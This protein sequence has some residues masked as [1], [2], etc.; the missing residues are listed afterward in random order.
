M[1]P[2]PLVIS[3]RASRGTWASSAAIWPAPK[4]ILVG[5]WKVKFCMGYALSE[6]MAK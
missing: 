1:L 5:L 3:T 2:P 6:L 4:I